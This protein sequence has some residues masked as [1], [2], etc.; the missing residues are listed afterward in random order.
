MNNC[1]IIICLSL[2]CC[3]LRRTIL[4]LLWEIISNLLSFEISND[5]Y[6]IWTHALPDWSLNPTPYTTQKICQIVQK[7][8]NMNSTCIAG[9]VF[10]SSSSIS[11]IEFGT[12]QALESLWIELCYWSYILE[13]IELCYGIWTNVL[14]YWSLNLNP[15]AIGSNSR[16]IKEDQ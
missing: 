11:S 8:N 2:L 3:F 16:V 14:P 12:K 9:H 1:A 15:S 7:Q 10:S 4:Q 5:N 13:P 6:G